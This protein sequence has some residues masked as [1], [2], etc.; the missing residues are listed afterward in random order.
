MKRL[1]KKNLWIAA[2]ASVILLASCDES[3]YTVHQTFFYPQKAD[4]MKLYADQTFDTTNVYSIDAWAAEI[5]GEWFDITPREAKALSNTHIKL[6]ASINQT[7][8]NRQGKIIV[9]SFETIKMSVYQCSWL[10]IFVPFARYSED[11]TFEDRKAIFEALADDD[12]HVTEIQF[13]VYQDGATL[14][15]NV[16]WLSSEITTFDKGS[17]VVK[18]NVGENPLAEK[19]NGALLLTSAGVSTPITIVQAEQVDE[20]AEQ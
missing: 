4:G 2:C 12:A 9:N 18:I 20:E 14:T 11:E 13:H 8:K 17:H 10:N 7:G 19:R 15:S 1:L 5:E 3:E 6:S 16:D